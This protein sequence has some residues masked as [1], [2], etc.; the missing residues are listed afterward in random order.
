MRCGSRDCVICVTHVMLG[1]W[2]PTTPPPGVCQG[3]L[4]P[5]GHDPLRLPH[6]TDPRYPLL[7]PL[8]L[9]AQAAGVKVQVL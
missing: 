5:T 6:G 9:S 1:G 2:F 4:P 7:L 8:W 3:V